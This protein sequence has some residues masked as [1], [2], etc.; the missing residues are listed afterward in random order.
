[1]LPLLF[2]EAQRLGFALP[3]EAEGSF[4]AFEHAC[5]D[6]LARIRGGQDHAHAWNSVRSA[7]AYARA[8]NEAYARAGLWEASKTMHLE[9]WEHELVHPAGLAPG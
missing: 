7:V 3:P 4:E 1:M 5:L 8:G 9:A 2:A 6:R